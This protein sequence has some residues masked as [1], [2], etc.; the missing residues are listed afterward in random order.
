MRDALIMTIKVGY[1]F[2]LMYCRT[3]VEV[4]IC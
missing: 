3:D 2:K 1:V 4:N